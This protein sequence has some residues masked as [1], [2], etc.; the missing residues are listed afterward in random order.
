MTRG[1]EPVESRR[2]DRGIQVGDQSFMR[3]AIDIARRAMLAGEPPIGA[4]LVRAGEAIVTLSNAVVGELDI[5]AHAEMRVI[6]AACR[7]L[8]VLTLSDCRLFVTVAPCPMCMSACHY[9]G[10]PEIVYGAE[11]ADLHA[12]TGNE[13]MVEG[14][15]PPGLTMSGGCLGDECRALFEEWSARSPG[16]PA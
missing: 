3:S 9:A 15:R 4:C 2:P 12:L 13:I 1:A 6:R 8:R 11:I 7:Q 5:T 10:I 16:G 14:S